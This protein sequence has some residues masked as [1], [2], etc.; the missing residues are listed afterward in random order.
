M[1][2]NDWFR[3]LTA[4]RDKEDEE[5]FERVKTE[6]LENG[7]EPFDLNKLEKLFDTSHDLDYERP[8]EQR[9]QTWA[10]KYF[11]QFP[12]PQTIRE[13]ADLMNELAPWHDAR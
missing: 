4:K 10:R 2:H 12:K 13:F 8:R 5:N 11:V 3:Q 9:E 7:K 6:A 1:S